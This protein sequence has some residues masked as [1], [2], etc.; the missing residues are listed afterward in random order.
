MTTMNQT[1]RH[2][3]FALVVGQGA[4]AT[5]VITENVPIFWSTKGGALHPLGGKLEAGETEQ[6]ALLRELAEEAGLHPGD[7]KELIPI[8]TYHAVYDGTQWVETMWVAILTPTATIRMERLSRSNTR[9]TQQQVPITRLCLRDIPAHRKTGAGSHLMTQICLSPAYSFGTLDDIT[10]ILMRQA[11][12][13]AWTE[14]ITA[15]QTQGCM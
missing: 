14:A 13:S 6:A 10:Y 11:Q 15:S 7:F 9:R 3:T 2:S 8:G 1:P 12:E 5:T 4:K